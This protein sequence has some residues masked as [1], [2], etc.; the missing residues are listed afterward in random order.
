MAEQRD[1]GQP[2]RGTSSRSLEDEPAPGRHLRRPDGAPS[3]SA[4]GPRGEAG[5]PAAPP[6]PPR[7]SSASPAADRAVPP[8]A[9]QPTG[10]L[11]I[12]SARAWAKTKALVPR[13]AGGVGVELEWF[14]VDLVEPGRCVP[15][16]RSRTAL[17]AAGIALEPTG[18]GPQSRGAGAVTAYA[19][20]PGGPGGPSGPSGPGQPLPGRSRITFEPGGQL[21]LSGP[22]L[23]L[24]RAI[25]AMRADVGAVQ[26]ALRAAGLGLAALGADPFRPPERVLR[27]PRYAAMARYFA[28]ASPSAGPLMMCSTASVQVNLN[29]GNVAESA[30]RFERA[31]LLEPVLTAMFAASPAVGGQ[32]TGWS[33]SRQAIWSELDRTRS[34]PVVTGGPSSSSTSSSTSTSISAPTSSPGTAWSSTAWPDPAGAWADYLLAAH[35]MVIR[36]EVDRFDA[37]TQPMPF[38]DWIGGRGPAERPPTIDDL[39]YHATTVFPPVRPRGWLEVRYLDAQPHGRWPVAVAVTTALMDDPDAGRAAGEL[40]KPLAGRALDAA[41]YGLADPDLRRAALG[42]AALAVEALPRLGADAELRAEVE[43]FVA[44]FVERGRCPADELRDDLAAAGPAGVLAAQARAGVGVRASTDAGTD[45]DTDADAD[46][47]GDRDATSVQV[48]AP[49]APAVTI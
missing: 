4:P 48:G 18:D 7:G 46:A 30:E 13:P 35:V 43:R 2:A 33:S 11:T 14:V 36:G 40:C 5:R 32:L 37:V 42:C 15:P 39:A 1:E 23:P 26:A 6:N 28:W 19:G 3:I 10:P 47:S 22:P 20:Q 9:G 38:A 25:A 41:R 45:T 8:P 29:A 24:D 27:E 21:E 34:A 17:A 44:S 12:A 31:H 16:E 49:M